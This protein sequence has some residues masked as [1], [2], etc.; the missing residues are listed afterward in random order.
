MEGSLSHQ[1]TVSTVEPAPAAAATAAAASGQLESM[2]L[3]PPALVSSPPHA[4]A[5]GT[6]TH[7]AP[8]TGYSA[9]VPPTPKQHITAS[10]ALTIGSDT[11]VNDSPANDTFFA[12]GVH[13]VDAGVLVG[14]QQHRSSV[15]RS[16][17]PVRPRPLSYTKPAINVLSPA[18]GV[19]VADGVVQSPVAT[20]SVDAT[21]AASEDG[22][23][24]GNAAAPTQDQIVVV[25]LP[26]EREVVID[27][28]SVHKDVAMLVM[29]PTKVRCAFN[30]VTKTEEFLEKDVTVFK[31]LVGLTFSVRL[32]PLLRSESDSDCLCCCLRGR[33]GIVP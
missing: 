16:M 33:Y 2:P 17:P 24:D 9:A 10:P 26:P 19:P 27:K 25:Q 11:T 22:H 21:A 4:T 29:S 28:P 14:P 13:K 15:R 5:A 3:S 20:P 7:S 1:V 23:A 12:R 6:P 8:G 32:Q 18:A 31:R 30:D